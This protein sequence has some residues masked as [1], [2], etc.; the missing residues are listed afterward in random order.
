MQEITQLAVPAM[1][2]SLVFYLLYIN[3]NYPHKS[4][5]KQNGRNL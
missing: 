1:V 2:V 3:R 5:G 4:T